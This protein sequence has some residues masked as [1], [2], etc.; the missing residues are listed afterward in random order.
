VFLE[1]TQALCLSRFLDLRLT[2]SLIPI[3]CLLLS[4]ELPVLILVFQLNH[5]HHLFRLL[6]RG[7]RHKHQTLLLQSR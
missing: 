2:L 7:A 4:Q 6:L 3:P 1:L 5:Y